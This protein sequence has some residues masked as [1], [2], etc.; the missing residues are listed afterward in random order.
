ML[1]T[2]VWEGYHRNPDGSIAHAQNGSGHFRELPD[3]HD[4]KQCLDAGDQLIWLDLTAPDEDELKL[5]A[6][7]FS[8]HP[9]AIE[10]AGKGNQRPKIDD[11]EHF[12]FMVVFALEQIEEPGRDGRMEPTGRFRIQEVD[13]FIGE[14]FLITVHRA[15]LPFLE[16]LRERW[17]KNSQAINE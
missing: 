2:H 10:D 7:E 9:L 15:P 17:R 12:Y 1:K 3:P 5:I 6:E 16:E 11:Y 14:R 13:L 8:L 4:I